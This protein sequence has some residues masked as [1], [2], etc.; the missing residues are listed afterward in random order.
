MKRTGRRGGRG[1]GGG[2]RGHAERGGGVDFSSRAITLLLFVLPG[3]GRGEC[4]TDLLFGGG[5]S[6]VQKRSEKDPPF[7][8]TLKVQ[9]CFL[10]IK[11]QNLL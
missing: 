11:W 6:R 5:E 9:N 4:L 1:G 7:M 3:N 8:C 10:V 2:G